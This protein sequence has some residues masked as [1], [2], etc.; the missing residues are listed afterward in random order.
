MLVGNPNF[1]TRNRLAIGIQHHPRQGVV[2]QLEYQR[3]ELEQIYPGLGFS[4]MFFS[5]ASSRP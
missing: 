3:F 5:P 1:R 4:V 2:Q